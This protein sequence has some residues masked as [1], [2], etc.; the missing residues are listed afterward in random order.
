MY[1]YTYALYV[2]IYIC[3]YIYKY[4]YIYIYIYIYCIH[5]LSFQ[6]YHGIK[7]GDTVWFAWTETPCTSSYGAGVNASNAQTAPASL[8]KTS[9]N[10][11]LMDEC[12]GRQYRLCS[13]GSGV[14]MDFN[15]VRVV[16]NDAYFRRGDRS[17]LMAGNLPLPVCFF[18]FFVLVCSTFLFLFYPLLVTYL[19]PYFIPPYHRPPTHLH[20]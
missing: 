17:P 7:Q 9:F 18:F 13:S 2:I 8:T 12:G 3:I 6:Y 20:T 15:D 19:P 10:F 14:T 16:V 11:G 5:Q 1:T 4:I